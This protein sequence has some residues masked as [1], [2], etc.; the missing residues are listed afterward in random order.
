ML[1]K[2]FFTDGG[3]ESESSEAQLQKALIAGAGTDAAA[4]EGGRA[5][6]VEDLEGSLYTILW[7]NREDL[8]LMN[9]LNKR[10]ISSNVHQFDVRTDIG[11]YKYLTYPELASPDVNDQ[12]ITRVIVEAAY[13]QDRRS[14]S[15]QMMTVGSL[16]DPV[17]EEQLAGTVNVLRG[18]EYLCFHGDKEIIPTQFNGLLYYVRKRAPRGNTVDLR[19]K[20]LTAEDTKYSPLDQLV[21]AI[22]EQGGSANKMFFPVPLTMQLQELARDRILFNVGDKNLSTVVERY[23]T[24][25]GN[26]EFGNEAG[27]DKMFHVKGVITADGNPDKR[28]N[29]VTSVTSALQD[30]ADSQFTAADTGTYLYTVYAVNGAG[31]S[32]G[33]KLADGAGVAV[34]TGKAVTLTIT[35]DTTRPVTG[36]IIT[37]SVK[38]GTAEMELTRIP[39][40]TTGTTVFTDNNEELPGTA[41]LIMITENKIQP[42]VEFGQLLP[43]Q[44][45][46]LYSSTRAETPFLIQ[47]YGALLVRAPQWCGMIKNIGYAGGLY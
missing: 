3:A 46:T 30:S 9:S 36:F 33:T 31:T 28:P 37:R 41:S 34:T 24:P 45:Y 43:L 27:A 35:P 4:F 29:P 22:Y 7:A 20:R 16:V 2:D 47:L 5:L 38:D 8:K 40:N 19:G 11:N 12:A 17:A 44:K 15:Y 26:V 25:L 1:T 10:K 42:I 14:V 39:A 23:P 21:Q 18:A 13:L 32:T 6:Q